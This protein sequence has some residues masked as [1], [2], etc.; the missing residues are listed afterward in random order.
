MSLYGAFL[1]KH[2][3]LRDELYYE[4]LDGSEE[5]V[6]NHVLSHPKTGYAEL[7]KYVGYTKCGLPPIVTNKV[8]YRN[9]KAD[10]YV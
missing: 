8:A 3:D 9:Q 5:I 4:S 10:F 7:G 6:V 2:A 1:S